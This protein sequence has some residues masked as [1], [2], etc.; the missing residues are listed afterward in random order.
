MNKALNFSV[1]LLLLIVL[2]TAC[3]KDDKDDDPNPA[4]TYNVIKIQ[5]NFGNIFIWLFDETPLHKNNFDSLTRA[6][7]YDGLIFHRVIDDFVIQGGDPLGTGSG[8]PGYKIPAE[9]KSNL[10]H[11]EGAVGAARDNNPLKE[12]NGSQFYIVENPNGTSSLDGEYTVFGQTIGGMD[13]VSLIA[14]TP[15]NSSDK[16]LT[17]VVMTK[18]EVVKYTASE[19]QADFG[20][21]VPQ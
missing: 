13:V 18:V 7:F 2:F 19:L 17:D 12:S 5:T 6:G 15:T 1:I 4:S 16:P 3:K 21:I 8:G 20:F 11:I 10:T 14:K 9:I